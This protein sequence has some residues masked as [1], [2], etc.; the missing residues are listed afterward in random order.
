MIWGISFW[1]AKWNCC[2]G[3]TWM[4]LFNHFRLATPSPRASWAN[5]ITWPND[6]YIHWQNSKEMFRGDDKTE[7]YH[8]L[9]ILPMK[10]STLDRLLLLVWILSY[11]RVEVKVSFQ[12]LLL[13][14]M[15]SIHF[16]IIYNERKS[17]TLTD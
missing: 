9:V 10:M 8:M 17:H 11:S 6:T 15:I 7:K 12:E 1:M 16:W 14:H 13:R 5:I 2:F 3:W 4:R